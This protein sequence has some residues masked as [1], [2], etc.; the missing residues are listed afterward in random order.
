[1]TA[2]PGYQSTGDLIADGVVFGT[3]K[4]ATSSSPPSA[5]KVDAKVAGKDTAR[6]PKRVSR[7]GRDG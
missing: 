5:R 7:S 6:L 2:R 4:P 3:T 1:M